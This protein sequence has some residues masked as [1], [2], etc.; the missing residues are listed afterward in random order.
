MILNST[1]YSGAIITWIRTWKCTVQKHLL[2]CCV[3]MQVWKQKEPQTRPHSKQMTVTHFVPI[4]RLFP[5]S[6]AIARTACHERLY[7]EIHISSQTQVN[8]LC[9]R[10]RCRFHVIFAGTPGLL[11]CLDVD[12]SIM[13]SL[14]IYRFKQI[15]RTICKSVYREGKLGVYYV[16][17][18][19][20]STRGNQ[21]ISKPKKTRC[22]SL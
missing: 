21:S 10:V 13:F 6:L 3:R 8:N 2:V 11:W 1:M 4:N 22:C 20:H 15:R 5:K 12:E 17:K 14:I 19:M 7:L 18:S 9:T 16:I